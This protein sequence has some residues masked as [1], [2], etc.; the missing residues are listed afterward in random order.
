MEMV[1]LTHDGLDKLKQ[2]LR[3]LLHVARSEATADLATAR[4]HGDLSENAEYDAAREKLA[5][6]D[7]QIG[8]LQGKLSRVHIIDENS[9]GTDE[10]R[11][12]SR[13]TLENLSNG[14]KIDYTIVD[15]LQAD[16]SKR[17]ISV[18]SPIGK[19]LL[20]KRVDD[21]VT[22]EVPSGEI[23]FKVLDIERARGI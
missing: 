21:E 17:L 5:K 14:S 13:V 10:V 16:P 4:A 22:I 23:C 15:P 6:I 11:I 7:V 19:G 12:L 1:Y 9:L 18:K 8:D 20:G 3:H 2:E